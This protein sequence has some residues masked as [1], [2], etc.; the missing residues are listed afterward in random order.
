MPPTVKTRL[1][2]GRVQGLRDVV[3]GG[4]VRVIDANTGK[5]LKDNQPV[6]YFDPTAKDNVRFET[7][8]EKMWRKKGNGRHKVDSSKH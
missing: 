5:V 8:A 3:S 7:S 4:P 6:G 2:H 1:I